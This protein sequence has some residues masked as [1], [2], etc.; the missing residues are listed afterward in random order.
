MK[1]NIQSPHFTLDKGLTEF[2]NNKVGKLSE[3]NERILKADVTLKFDKSGKD[4]DKVC[5]IKLTASEK[6]LFASRKLLTFED[7]ITHT[8]KALEQQIVKKKTKWDGGNE[9]MQ[10]EEETSEE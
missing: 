6:N 9:T 1:I 5:E 2:V 3:F 10:M 7:A 8:V 4:D